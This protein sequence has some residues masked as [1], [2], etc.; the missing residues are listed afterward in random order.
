MSISRKVGNSV[1]RNLIKRMSREYFRHSPLKNYHY[2]L[3]M[4]ARVPAGKLNKE[5]LFKNI[6]HIFKLL[7]HEL[8]K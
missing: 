8:S 5:D 4:V 3:H 2:D 7:D 1:S 6:Q